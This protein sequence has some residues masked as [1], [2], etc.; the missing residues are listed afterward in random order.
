M[1]DLSYRM[2]DLFNFRYFNLKEIVYI[3]DVVFVGYMLVY[4]IIYIFI[5][6]VFKYIRLVW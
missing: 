2:I 6:V 4:I 1:E 3:L 5:Y